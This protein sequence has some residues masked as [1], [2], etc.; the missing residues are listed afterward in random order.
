MTASEMIRIDGL[1]KRFGRTSVLGQLDLRVEAGE[2]F[3]FLGRNGAGKTTTIRMLLGLLPPDGGS[4]RV[5]GLDPAR[6]A[7]EIRRRVGYLAE[8]QRMWGWMRVEQ[9]L[10]FMAPFYPT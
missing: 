1:S 3:A 7:L 6:H 2:T 8:D 5:L 10:R 9:L 4:V